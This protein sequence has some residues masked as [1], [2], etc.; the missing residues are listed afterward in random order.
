MCYSCFFVHVLT[1]VSWGYVICLFS[2]R[3][4]TSGAQDSVPAKD[5][6]SCIFIPSVHEG[7]Q[8]RSHWAG[9]PTAQLKSWSLTTQR[10]SCRVR[11]DFSFLQHLQ[12]E[13][14]SV[15]I[16][17]SVLPASTSPRT[18]R[19]P[20]LCL[21][22]CKMEPKVLVGIINQYQASQSL[23]GR[24]H[25]QTWLMTANEHFVVCVLD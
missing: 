9:G 6:P 3:L 5:L 8:Q 18:S 20:H 11:K 14:E 7:L 16:F 13:W 15:L 12:P 24:Y 10:K 23:W 22:D 1:P 17:C 25:T 4:G 21:L 19:K 2:F